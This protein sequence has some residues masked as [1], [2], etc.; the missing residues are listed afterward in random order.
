MNRFSH[1]LIILLTVSD[2]MAGL[3]L[4]YSWWTLLFFT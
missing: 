3:M 1:K 4:Q 2:L